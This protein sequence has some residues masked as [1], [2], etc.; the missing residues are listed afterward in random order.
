MEK[1]KLRLKIIRALSA[2]GKTTFADD[3][4]TKNPSF[5]K[6]ERDDIRRMLYGQERMWKGDEDL[7]TKIQEEAV[8]SAFRRGFS[9][10]SSDTNLNIKYV[11]RLKQLA[12]PFDA[13]VEIDESLLEIPVQI[14]LERDRERENPVG[15]KVILNQ[16]Q[17]HVKKKITPLVQDK[18]KPHAV[19]S[20]LDGTLCLFEKEDKSQPHYRNPYDAS[21]CQND[22][23]NKPVSDVLD[24]ADNALKHVILVSG[25]DEKYRP[26][27]E[28]WLMLYNIPY[29]HLYMRKTGDNRKDSIIKREIYENE[30]LPHYHVDFI[31]DDRHQVVEEIRSMGL[32]VFQ[33][34]EG[35]F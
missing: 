8:I 14:C 1:A 20:D 18:N 2:S 3:F 34:D 32:V 16:Y 28:E 13:Q 27:T 10:I 35:L 7:V 17:R 9:V 6:V 24:W 23:L 11:N 4:V 12:L 31:L 21:T 15:S 22:R 30:I 33:V 29:T 19:I 5:V 26:Q 25:R